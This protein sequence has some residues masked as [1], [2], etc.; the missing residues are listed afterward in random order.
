MQG[1]PGLMRLGMHAPTPSIS[2]RQ[3]ARSPLSCVG[4][5]ACFIELLFL[6]GWAQQDHRLGSPSLAQTV[7]DHR[8]LTFAAR[9]A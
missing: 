2:V 6:A 8:R 1:Y 9:P 4:A 5:S 7:Q 3:P